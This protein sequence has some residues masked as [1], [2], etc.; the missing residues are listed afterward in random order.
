MFEFTKV[1]SRQNTSQ[2]GEKG[3]YFQLLH[4]PQLNFVFDGLIFLKP[5]SIIRKPPYPARDL[6]TSL[7]KT[8]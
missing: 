5:F 2:G 1:S 3:I 6:V 7:W 8:F 4:L